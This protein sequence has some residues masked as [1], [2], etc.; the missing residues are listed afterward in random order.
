MK[1]FILLFLS[2]TILYGQ[3]RLTFNNNSYV[4]I[5]TAYVVL[6]NPN[7][8]AIVL[9]G[10]GGNIITEAEVNRLRWL[11][12]TSTGTYT[13]PFTKSVGNKIP[14]SINITSAGVGAGSFFDFSTYSTN[15]NNITY[16]TGVTHMNRLFSGGVA[17]ALNVTDR[18]WIVNAQNYTTKPASTLSFTYLDA[19]NTPPGNTLVENNLKAQRWST[20]ENDWA[21]WGPVGTVNTINKTVSNVVV[22][23]KD[24]FRAWTLVD[25]MTPLPV[26]LGNFDIECKENGTLVSWST[27]SETNCDYYEILKSKDGIQYYTIASL[28][29]N[30]NSNTIHYYDFLD[31]KTIGVYYY[32]LNQIDYDGKVNTYDPKDIFCKEN[33]L[34]ITYTQD[35]NINIYFNTNSIEDIIIS[36]FDYTGRLI[37]NT[38]IKTDIEQTVYIFNT[39]NLPK[40]IYLLNIKTKYESVNEK[41]IIN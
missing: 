2:I 30:G 26:L 35:D 40:N 5:K 4:V 37:Q 20:T 8:N 33:S 31:K 17:N 41:L 29:G 38:T 6:A 25:Y 28:K 12:G 27:L 36:L 32:K 19:E 10:T 11:I 39:S 22:A 7:S 1:L 3:G 15:V 14:F 34:R 24:L 21:I 13:T 23:P 9:Y 18:F 16:P